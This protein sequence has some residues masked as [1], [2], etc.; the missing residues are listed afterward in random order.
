MGFKVK[1]SLQFLVIEGFTVIRKFI[2][3]PNDKV[4]HCGENPSWR[5]EEAACHAFPELTLFARKHSSNN[6]M[7]E[8]LQPPEYLLVL[9]AVEEDAHG[10]AYRR[11]QG[12]LFRDQ[13]GGNLS[14][15]VLKDREASLVITL[16]KMVGEAYSF[17]SNRRICL[18]RG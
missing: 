1:E 12:C 7:P 11:L 10:Q 9:I 8:S 5:K 14:R 13:T 17:R 6:I 18:Q 16:P 3:V 15:E 2:H 4:N